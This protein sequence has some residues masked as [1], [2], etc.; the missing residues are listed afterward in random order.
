MRAVHE[1]ETAPNRLPLPRFGQLRSL[2]D[3]QALHPRMH[4]LRS[5][6]LAGRLD[7]GVGFHRL[8]DQIAHLL[9][10]SRMPLDGFEY[11]TVC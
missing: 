4:I 2:I 1:R 3:T 7:F 10:V 9:F 8:P 6:E 5:V 11:Q